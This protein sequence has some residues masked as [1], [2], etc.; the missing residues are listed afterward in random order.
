MWQVKR[1]PLGLSPR[2]TYGA[3]TVFVTDTQE[4]GLQVGRL[5]GTQTPAPL[6][7]RESSLSPEATSLCHWLSELQGGQAGRNLWVNSQPP[8]GLPSLL[9]RLP[10]SPFFTRDGQPTPRRNSSIHH[11]QFHLLESSPVTELKSF[12]VISALSSHSMPEDRDKCPRHGH[13]GSL[14][15]LRSPL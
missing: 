11:Q 3:R 12:S 14:S 10:L 6:P 9:S 15:R 5:G 13:Q 4:L 8:V 2:V 7:C 1:S